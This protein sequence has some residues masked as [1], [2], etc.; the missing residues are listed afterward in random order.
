MLEVYIHCEIN[1][2]LLFSKVLALVLV[3]KHKTEILET[4]K[5]LF[6]GLFYF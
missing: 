5:H 6:L 1:V 2:K 4:M 3:L